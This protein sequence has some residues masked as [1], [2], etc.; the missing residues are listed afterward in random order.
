MP[1]FQRIA[2]IGGG[3]AGALAAAQLAGGGRQVLLFDE[4]LAW[5]KP[6]G[7]GLTDKALAHWPFLRD[8][9]VER[10]WVS[11][12]ELIAPSGRRVQFALDR[13][14]AIFS[15]MALNGLLLD[16][17][18]DAGATLRHERVLQIDG[19]GSGWTIRTIDGIYSADFVVL[20]AGARNSLRT[21][22]TTALG[23][24]NFMVAAGY[25]IP[26]NRHTTQVKF[27][28]DL[29]GY[30]WIFPRADHFSA[31]ICGRIQGKSTAELRRI[32]EGSLPEFGLSLN[33][34]RF[35]AHIIPSLTPDTLRNSSLA[36]NGWAMIGD[37]AGFVDAITGEGL[38]YALRSAELLSNALQAGAPENYPSL[39]KADFL[40]ELEH[41]ARIANRFYSGE[42]MGGHV[43]ERMIQLT[44]SS[45]SFREIM[46]DL[47]SGAQEYSDLRQRVYKKLPRIAMEAVVSTLWNTLHRRAASRPAALGA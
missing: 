35:Y 46:R 27:L 29:H 16:R 45:A 6:C 42:W 37:A 26:G 41:A 39:V 7:G 2:I 44:L 47:F 43:L 8:S 21:R 11:D 5:E 34:A 17:A 4:K 1:V 18:R 30:I 20:A 15:R 31:G 13:Q 12:C 36:G 10:N 28:K 38:Y 25:Y 33:G 24:E 14:I 40:P 22:F 9:P 19:S 23:P 3:P 32:L